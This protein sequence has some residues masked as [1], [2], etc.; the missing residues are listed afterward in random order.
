MW[1]WYIIIVLLVL[2]L[3]VMFFH[4]INRM[5]TK[6]RMSFLEKRFDDDNTL[7]YFSHTDYTNMTQKKFDFMSNEVELK[8]F[9]YSLESSEHKG[10]LVFVHGMGV[11][12]IQYMNDINYY[13]RLGYDVYTFDGQGCN[14]SEGQG[15]GYFSN[16]VRNLDDF[17][18]YIESLEDVKDK[19]IILVGHS[20][21]GY[22]VNVIAKFHLERISHIVS[23]SGFNSVYQLMEDK[24]VPS[25][26]FIGKC[27]A[28]ELAKQDKKNAVPY[29]LR[30]IDVVKEFKPKIL[31]IHGDEDSV[32]LRNRTYDLFIKE[33]SDIDSCHFMLVKGR[34]HN[35]YVTKESAAYFKYTHEK[36]AE[37]VKKYGNIPQEELD[38]YYNSLDYKL[39]VELDY[40]VMDNVARFLNNDFKEKEI[41]VE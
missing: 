38:A 16:F 24:L 30:S 9:L 11:G 33:L 7:H 31:F 34:N 14:E 10:I 37:L 21:G 5:A 29:S 3:V 32:V 12:H 39:L 19:K 4:S 25:L 35:P 17:L 40:T 27:I 18:N 36:F 8:G 23:F 1:Y 22:A 20:M 13:C 41:V 15:I 28:K 26:K 6:I 2:L